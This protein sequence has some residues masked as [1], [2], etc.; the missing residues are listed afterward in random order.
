M[1]I[2]M[3]NG[4]WQKANGKRGFSTLFLVIILAVV[5][6]GFIGIFAISKMNYS[7]NKQPDTQQVEV[8]DQVKTLQSLSNSDEIGSIEQDINATNFDNLDD[9]INEVD[10]ELSAF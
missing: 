9:G 2:K 7:I 5:I 6:L 10:R 8:D 4:K 1:Q 3:A